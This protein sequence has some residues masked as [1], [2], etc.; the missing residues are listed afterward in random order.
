MWLTSDAPLTSNQYQANMSLFHVS[1][2]WDH[3]SLLAIGRMNVG[4][5]YL[6]SDINNQSFKWIKTYGIIFTQPSKT[7]NLILIKHLIMRVYENNL[8]FILNQIYMYTR[9]SVGLML[10]HRLWGW[11]N[12]NITLSKRLIRFRVFLDHSLTASEWILLYVVFCTL[13]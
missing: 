13:R 1:C 12:I 2:W 7:L 8:W 6:R 3:H 10:A 11:V 4:P 9:P 5:I